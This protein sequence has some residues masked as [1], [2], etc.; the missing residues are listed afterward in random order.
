MNIK[1]IIDR[2]ADTLGGYQRIRCPHCPAQIRFRGCGDD[3]VKRFQTYMHDHI[4][5]HTA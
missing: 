1:Q 2:I 4:S 3:E 5:N